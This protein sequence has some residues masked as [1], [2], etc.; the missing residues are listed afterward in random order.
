MS[1]PTPTI[2]GVFV[3]S[4][5]RALERK[6]GT[7]ALEQLRGKYGALLDF[8]D[9]DDVPVRQE[10]Q[11]LEAI[12]DITSPQKLPQ[13]ERELEAGR[14]HFRNFTTTPLWRVVTSVFGSNFK[15]L[16][17]QSHVIAGRVFRGVD[18][19][20]QSVGERCVRI[21]M[22]NNDYPIEHFHGFFEE[23]IAQAGL[24]GYV[25]A[26]ARAERVYEY[27]ISWQEPHIKVVA[28]R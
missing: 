2:R 19:E 5:L 11:L 18:F 26:Y 1:L 12:V 4:H 21:V 6:H 28:E 8:G 17:M 16:L 10:V 23:W 27:V 14:L 3:K 25:E 24:S 13:K 20:S 15:L 22:R 9:D 7:E